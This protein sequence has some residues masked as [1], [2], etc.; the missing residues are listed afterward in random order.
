MTYYSCTGRLPCGRREAE[1]RTMILI[2][3]APFLF[4]HTAG[5][6][7]PVPIWPDKEYTPAAR[8]RLRHRTVSGG[9]TPPLRRFCFAPGYFGREA[10]NRP[11]GKRDSLYKK[12]GFLQSLFFVCR[13]FTAAAPAAPL[14]SAVPPHP[15]L[16]QEGGFG[17]GGSGSPH[18][19]ASPL[20]RQNRA[21]S[22]YAAALPHIPQA[23]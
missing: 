3:A 20:R 21:R 13:N 14:P 15:D 11:P 10:G 7:F 6:G 22:P 8:Y 9:D 17:A 23:P 16:P 18:Q 4:L 19:R 2:P 1:S 5:D 12:T